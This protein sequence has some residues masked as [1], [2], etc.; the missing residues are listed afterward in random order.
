MKLIFKIS[1]N[2]KRKK[3]LL[4]EYKNQFKSNKFTDKRI[5]ENDTSLTLD[6]KMFKRFV[7][8]RQKRK[9]R[10]SSK[11][12]LNDDND[13]L[14]GGPSSNQV[15]DLTHFGQSLAQIEKFEKVDLSDD[16]DD[17]NG[18]DKNRGKIDGRS[19]IFLII[20]N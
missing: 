5:G 20:K 17:E 12:N 16:D 13:D 19:L 7:A 15:E 11:Y 6:D 18:D 3:T 1:K 8:E 14:D 10:K 4:V 2:L 9:E